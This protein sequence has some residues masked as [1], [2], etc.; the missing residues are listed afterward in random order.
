MPD[1]PLIAANSRHPEVMLHYANSD[2]THKQAVAINGESG[3]EFTVKQAKYKDLYLA[4][5]SAEGSSALKI[6]LIYTDGSETKDF[7]LPDYYRDLPANDPD[8]C[9]LVHDLAKWGTKNNMTEKDHHNIDLLNIHPN[10][11]KTLK[12]ISINKTKLGYLV[13][14]AA[15][16]VI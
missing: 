9:Y 10:P 14:W 4:L 8:L 15:T 12:G 1:N 13:F 6:K 3:V 7:V 2:S 11:E 5:T 16:G